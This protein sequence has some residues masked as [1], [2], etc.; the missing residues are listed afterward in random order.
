[1]PFYD[2]W[3]RKQVTPIGEWLNDQ[4]ARFTLNRLQQNLPNLRSLVE[5]GPGRGALAALCHASQYTYY[6]IDVNIGLLH[7]LPDSDRV[8]AFVPP[9]PLD[10]GIVDA[11]Q[12]RQRLSGRP[13]RRGDYLLSVVG[14]EE[15]APIH[16]SN[17]T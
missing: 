15:R 9:L 10:D 14:R 1:M 16:V 4:A 11:W 5:I 13:L 12:L 8:C 2:F 6:A 7:N 3:Q 17:L